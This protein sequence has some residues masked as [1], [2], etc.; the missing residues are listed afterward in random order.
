MRKVFEDKLFKD[1]LNTKIRLNIPTFLIVFMFR[2]IFASLF[3]S[4]DDVFTHLHDI[5]LL[6]SKNVSDLGTS[7]HREYFAES[8]ITPM[9]YYYP[10]KFVIINAVL[11]LS[12]SGVV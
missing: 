3:L 8:G 9:L 6:Q 2:I 10:K 7:C 12:I 4:F 5:Q 1:F 11:L